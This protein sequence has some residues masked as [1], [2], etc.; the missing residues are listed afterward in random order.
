MECATPNPVINNSGGNP[1]QIFICGADEID[2]HRLNHITHIVRINNPNSAQPAPNWFTGQYLQLFFGDVFSRA[3]AVTCRT[4]AA[5]KSDIEQ[6]LTFSQ[7]AE[8]L[9]VSC[10]YGASRSP[11]IA[12][13][14]LAAKFGVGNEQEALDMVFK[15]RP[16]SMPNEYVVAL[17]DLLLKRSGKLLQT[18]RDSYE[19]IICL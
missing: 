2:Q 18:L 5:D 4:R 15:V 17:G 10:D 11:A 9:L 19:S 6:V 7:N 3:D 12:L 16:E 14:V 1:V 8:S 13:I